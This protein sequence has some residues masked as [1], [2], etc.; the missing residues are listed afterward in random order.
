MDLC[1]AVTVD[2]LNKTNFRIW[3]QD[4]TTILASKGLSEYILSDKVEVV[5]NQIISDKIKKENATALQ[6]IQGLISAD[7]RYLT[8]GITSA[9]LAWQAVLKKFQAQNPVTASRLRNQILKV[10]FDDPS[11]IEESIDKVTELVRELKLVQSTFNDQD[12]VGLYMQVLQSK[13]SSF[14]TIVES[15]MVERGTVNLHHFR[16]MLINHAARLQHSTSTQKVHTIQHNSQRNSHGQGHQNG[17]ARRQ[18]INERK[19]DFHPHSNS[20]WTFECR[21]QQ[22]GDTY[23]PAGP[24]RIPQSGQGHI[25]PTPY[26]QQP[27]TQRRLPPQTHATASNRFFAAP[28]ANGQQSSGQRTHSLGIMELRNMSLA[29][30]P[31]SPGHRLHKRTPHVAI[32]RI[33]RVRPCA[34]PL[35]TASTAPS[36]C[37]RDR[38]SPTIAISRADVPST[39]CKANITRPAGT[40]RTHL[41]RT[42]AVTKGPIERDDFVFTN[43]PMLSGYEETQQPQSTGHST[44]TTAPAALLAD[45]E[46][47]P[48]VDLST[49]PDQVASPPIVTSPKQKVTKAI[50]AEP[51]A[52]P[53]AHLA[54]IDDHDKSKSRSKSNTTRATNSKALFQLPQLNSKSLCTLL[55][56]AAIYILATSSYTEP[57][58][59]HTSMLAVPIPG[60]LI[61]AGDTP[62]NWLSQPLGV[63]AT[64]PDRA[65]VEAIN[66]DITRD[67]N[68]HTL[69]GLDLIRMLARLYL[70]NHSHVLSHTQ[71]ATEFQKLLLD[72]P[73]ETGV[74]CKLRTHSTAF[75]C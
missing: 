64:A 32:P 55:F 75:L 43:L 68:T 29:P 48:A 46:S 36:N 11:K 73:Q 21:S 41:Q 61:N 7:L 22:Q 67:T 10:S 4:I 8:D 5:D 16:E 28:T 9:Y 62:H 24:Q 35:R 30:L 44:R 27:T 49:V 15:M 1:S 51:K 70:A 39:N 2:K 56:V 42:A 23:G 18:I 63:T 33:E 20:H 38:P 17:R 66:E 13:Y 37:D 60:S 65:P 45:E 47:K 31:L 3:K 50:T 52:L 40:N 53:T 26:V 57:Q 74:Y 12:E 14:V 71:L 59:L 58:G 34:N 25:N 6:Y 19:C 54:P 69:T 72:P